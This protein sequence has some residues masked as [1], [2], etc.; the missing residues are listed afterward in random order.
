MYNN[1]CITDT[2]TPDTLFD[3]TGTGNVFFD[4]AMTQQVYIAP[5]DVF[6]SPDLVWY[7][8][9]FMTFLL[10]VIVAYFTSKI[11]NKLMN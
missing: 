7:L 4:T 5:C 3:S 8:Q 9:F 6:L 2:V 11:I 1:F 10:F